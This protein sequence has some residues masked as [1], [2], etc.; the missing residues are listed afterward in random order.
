[1]LHVKA[2]YL[3]L[4]ERFVDGRLCKSFAGSFGSFHSSVSVLSS[5]GRWT[6]K[7]WTSLFARV[8]VWNFLVDILWGR[9]EEWIRIDAVS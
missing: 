9:S 3:L 1:M 2:L 6:R 8:S 7:D 4:C 5:S